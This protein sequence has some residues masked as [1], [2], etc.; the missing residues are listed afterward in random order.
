MAVMVKFFKLNRYRHP[1]KGRH[2]LWPLVA[3][4]FLV[5]FWL[6]LELISEKA[7]DLLFTLTILP[8]LAWSVVVSFRLLTSHSYR[9]RTLRRR[10]YLAEPA[11][12]FKTCFKRS[13][14][15]LELAK[16]SADRLAQLK[17]SLLKQ[18]DNWR[19]CDVGPQLPRRL[20]STREFYTVFEAK[21]PRVVPHLIFDSRRTKGQQLKRLFLKAQRL[22]DL[23]VGFDEF[24]QAYSP[25]G[26]QI[27][28]LSFITPEVV[29]AMIELKDY[30]IELIDDSLFCYADLLSEVELAELRQ[31]ADNLLTKLNHNLTNYKDNR[32]VGAGRYKDITD[33]GSSLLKNP[34]RLRKLIIATGIGSLVVL[35]AAVS[36]GR[37]DILANKASVYCF[38]IFIFLLIQAF[39]LSQTNKRKQAEFETFLGSD[40]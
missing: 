13:A 23:A 28:A 10:T 1:I 35:V 15:R 31:K 29:E 3:S 11:L 22:P 38:G 7:A 34:W 9:S 40:K 36:A 25:Q 37:P 17:V 16:G 20:T 12:A 8:T 24:F 2:L 39:K 5:S 4:T 32:L 18:G 14:I 19:I 30:D 21:L 6:D 33:F 27:D 26:Y